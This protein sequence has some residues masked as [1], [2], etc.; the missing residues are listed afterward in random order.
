MYSTLKRRGNDH[1]HVVSTW[2][3]RSVFATTKLFCQISFFLMVRRLLCALLGVQ[4]G[5]GQHFRIFTTSNSWTILRYVPFLYPL[6]KNE[7]NGYDN[8]LNLYLLLR[9]YPNRKTA[10][11]KLIAW[12]PKKINLNLRLP[13]SPGYISIF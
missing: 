8:G 3:P 9:V 10:C 6:K 7:D 11:I 1:F 2:N 12:K 13:G 5:R 4:V